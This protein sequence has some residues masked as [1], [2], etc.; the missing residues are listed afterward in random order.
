[1]SWWARSAERGS[2]KCLADRKERTILY[3]MRVAQNWFDSPLFP[4]H[5]HRA[6]QS[7]SETHGCPGRALPS[8]GRCPWSKHG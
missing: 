7:Q 8:S 6:S 2:I 1:M 4:W 3:P 5:P